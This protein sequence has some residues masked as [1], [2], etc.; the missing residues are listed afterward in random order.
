MEAIS[1]S[2]WYMVTPPCRRGT[3]TLMVLRCFSRPLAPSSTERSLKNWLTWPLGRYSMVKSFT[4]T[5]SRAAAG[6]GAKGAPRRKPWPISKDVPSGTITEPPRPPSPEYAAPPSVRSSPAC[7]PIGASRP[8]SP[9]NAYIFFP[10]TNTWYPRA[11]SRSARSSLRARGRDSAS[12][13]FSNVAGLSRN[14]QS[15]L[16]RHTGSCRVNV[17]AVRLA[18]SAASSSRKY[19]SV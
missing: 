8:M 9:L 14:F 4:S 5:L 10:L 6:V 18:A 17:Q 19:H 11:A 13:I 3:F 2:V 12:S 15:A 1:Q 7:T 16:T